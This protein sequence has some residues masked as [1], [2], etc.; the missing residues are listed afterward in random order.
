M[1]VIEDIDPP[2]HQNSPALLKDSS[3]VVLSSV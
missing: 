3:A 2:W 1:L